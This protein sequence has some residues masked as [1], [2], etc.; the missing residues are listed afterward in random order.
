MCLALQV[1]ILWLQKSVD[2]S[3]PTVKCIAVNY[4]S[5]VLALSLS[6]FFFFSVREIV[7][8]EAKVKVQN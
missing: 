2:G 1:D 6:I 8:A 3:Q 7:I 4:V 5:F